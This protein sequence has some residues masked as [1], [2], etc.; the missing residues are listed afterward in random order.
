MKTHL[1]TR[2]L[3]PAICLVAMAALALAAGCAV[4]PDYHR[5]AALG[6]NAVP[7]QFGDV[8]ITNEWKTAEPAAQLP[9]GAWW[10][11]YADAELDRLETLSASNNQQVAVG[12]ANFDQAR[13][14][15]KVAQADFFPQISANPAAT[16]QRT[17][18]NASSGGGSRTNSSFSNSSRTFNTFNVSADASWEL[19]VFGRIRRLTEAARTQ[20]EA[21]ADDLESLKLS[22]QAEVA[23]D[24]FTLR[25]L[26]DQSA[27]LNQMADAYE[28][29]LRLTQNRKKS[30]IAD[31]LD[32]AQAETL[33]NSTRAQIPAVD[34]QRAQTRHALAV[35]C[36]QAATTFALQPASAGSSNPPAIPLSVPSE[37]LESRPD[38]SA[39]ERQMAAANANVG[40]ATAAF[41]PRI[42]LNGSGGFQSVSA[43][44][45]FAWPSH[46]WA[47]GPSL[48]LPLFTGG[49]NRAQLA[50]AKAAYNGAVATYRQ[51][52]LTAFQDVEDQ[53][54]AQHYLANQL[55]EEV[56]ALASARRALAI[57]NNRYKAG[58]E[59]YLD[60]IVAQTSELTHEQTVIQLRGQRL[61]T[62]VALIKSL[63][64]GWKPA[65]TAS[66]ER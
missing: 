19:D 28:T 8:S 15:V 3:K 30:G 14:A 62:S 51:T 42:F 29:S 26:D 24:Y 37:W 34:L 7:A 13:A 9:R 60:V 59:Q 31:D 48:Q 39:A 40:V 16:R 61:A 50:S 33:L 54:A 45:L 32:V 64:A 46:V 66:L 18:A 57:A 38:I 47:V 65:F 20:F 41:Y 10:N 6:T 55:D 12:V 44:D 63:G 36:G 27:A 49:A 52:V 56:A 1:E 4:G 21:S 5:P 22:I 25:S 17:S 43:S 58:V 53:L 11:I 2:I 35:L 23:I